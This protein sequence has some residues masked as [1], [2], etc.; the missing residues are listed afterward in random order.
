MKTIL[1]K[2]I[3][4]IDFDGTITLGDTRV[5]ANDFSSNDILIRRPQ[6]VDWVI[7]NRDSMYLILWTCS[8]GEDL[9]RAVNYCRERLGIEF[10]AINENI[11]PYETSAKILAD[12]YVD[13]KA[14]TLQQL[15]GLTW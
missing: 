15:G 9:Q 14:V 6:V 2:P 5:W 13:D 1:D 11:V 4:A 3:V 10:D 7:K 8:C 12:Y